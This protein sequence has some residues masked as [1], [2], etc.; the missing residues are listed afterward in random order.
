[1]ANGIDLASQITIV[2]DEQ[3]CRA[4]PSEFFVSLNGNIPFENIGKGKVTILFRE[5]KVL[6]VSALTLADS[7]ADSQ[8]SVTVSATEKQLIS[9]DIYN[10]ATGTYSSG[11][12]RPII[13]VYPD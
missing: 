8:K 11:E 6:S 4:K 13:I 1:M 2:S 7:G 10:H 5:N 3:T 9:Y 12:A